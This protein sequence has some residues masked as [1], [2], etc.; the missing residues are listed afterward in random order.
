MLLSELITSMPDAEVRGGGNPEITDITLDS[1]T[2]SAGCLFIAVTGALQDGHAFIADAVAKGA[3]AV[4]VQRSATAEDESLLAKIPSGICVILVT[5][6]LQAL[7]VV[8]A[9]FWSRQPAVIAAVTGTGGKTSTAQFLR[10]IWQA[11]GRTSASIGTL[12]LVT[13]KESRYGSLTTPD[14]LTLHRTLDETAVSGTT[15]VAM[16][17]SSHGIELHRLDQVRLQ[18]AGFTNLSRDHLDYHGDMDSYLAAKLQLFSRILPRG[19]AAVLN[20]DIPEYEVVAQTCRNA[21]HTVLS[22]GQQGHG[23]RLLEQRNQAAGQALTLEVAG[24]S[25]EI[26]LPVIGGFQAW[27]AMCALGLAMACGEDGVGAAQALETI[28]CVPGRLDLAGHT[29][30]GATVF[31]DYAHKPDALDNVLRTLR[32]HAMAQGGRLDVVFG[33]GGNRDKGKRALMGA[34]AARLADTV[35]VTDDNPRREDASTIRQEVLAGCTELIG[36]AVIKE[37]ADR[38]TAIRTAIAGLAKG[39]VLV[40]AGKG[41][42]SGQIVGDTVLPFDDMV[43]ARSCL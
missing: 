33:C 1:R 43:I 36:E 25:L 18:A 14:A 28:T 6:V 41:H 42:E 26:K 16:E 19:S 35:I 12:G 11:R 23:I 30:N 39:D 38:E 37:I 40:I 15:H 10:E 32:P 24:Q 34:I 29:A 22:Y 4:L 21:G 2:S 7:A 3:V 8:A 20:A 9:K 31:I 13:A 27:N 17:A 5:D